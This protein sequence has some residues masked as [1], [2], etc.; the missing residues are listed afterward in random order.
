MIAFRH[1]YKYYINYFEY[2][3]L[4]RRLRTILNNDKF[5]D[6]NGEYH[7]R[8]LYFDDIRNTALYEKQSGILSR[9]KYRIRIYNLSSDVI[10]LEKKERVGQF[11]R[12][13]SETLTKD[14]LDC[15]INNEFHFLKYKDNSKLFMQFYLDLTINRYE[16]K[17]IVDYFREAYVCRLNNI[18]ITFDKNLRT[19]L[20]SKDL[21][22]NIPTID[23]IEEPKMILEVKYNSYLPDY[24]RDILQI[25]SNQRYAISKYVVCRKF[26]K[27]NSWE[28]N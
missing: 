24:I 19:G 2:E 21:L 22:G 8:S 10:K 7:I 4:R 5:S 17:V 26:T 14:E 28:D 1:E 12:K 9:K 13:E 20:Y 11:I 23:V 18:R 15:L 16:P 3:V 27:H 25:S 6:K